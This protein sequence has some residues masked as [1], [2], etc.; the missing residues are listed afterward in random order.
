M[1]KSVITVLLCVLF[2]LP[3]MAQQEQGDSELQLLGSYLTPTGVEDP[4]GFYMVQAKYGYYFTDSFEFGTG[5]SYQGTTEEDGYWI[6]GLFPFFSYSFLMGDS[7]TV[8]YL[9]AQYYLFITEVE[10]YNL[11][12]YESEK[13][14]DTM[15]FMGVSG[16]FKQYV[17]PKVAL[18]LSGNYHFSLEKEVEGGMLLIMLGVSFLF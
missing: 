6:V 4:V 2:A 15:S 9:A 18:D 5:A 14:T 13:K 12:T 7:K 11:E 10:E 3:A 17:S 16:G 1:K 8:P